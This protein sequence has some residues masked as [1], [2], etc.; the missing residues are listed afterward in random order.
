MKHSG[1]KNRATHYFNSTLL[2]NYLFLG[3]IILDV[4]MKHSKVSLVFFQQNPK[5]SLTQIS[6]SW[7]I[8]H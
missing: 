3:P 4:L 5:G 8:W 6:D 7:V 1:P 2:K